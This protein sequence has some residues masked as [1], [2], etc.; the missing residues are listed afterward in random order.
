[1][2]RYS[3][4]IIIIIATNVIILEFLYTSFVHIGT[5]LLAI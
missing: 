5:P 2:P 3:D 4:N 1:M